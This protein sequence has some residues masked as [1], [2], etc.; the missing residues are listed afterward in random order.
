MA[1][2][3]PAAAV[4]RLEDL[5]PPEA[6][7]RALDL[8]IDFSAIKNRV[9]KSGGFPQERFEFTDAKRDRR[10]RVWLE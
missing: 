5:L 1:L 3:L 8:A 6:L 10:Y 2:E 7:T 9:R 4:E